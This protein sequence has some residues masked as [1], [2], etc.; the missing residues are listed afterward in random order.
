M[1]DGVQ[2]V[3]VVENPRLPDLLMRTWKQRL[4]NLPW[5]PM[6]KWVVNNNAYFYTDIKTNERC[7]QVSTRSFRKLSGKSV[8]PQVK[9]V[10]FDALKAVCG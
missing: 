8:G 4:F 2:R 9:Y 6:T 10:S 5:H 7:A 1:S 3:K